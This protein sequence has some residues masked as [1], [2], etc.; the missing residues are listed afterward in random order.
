MTP[1]AAPTSVTFSPPQV[2]NAAQIRRLSGQHVAI[3][4]LSEGTH[5]FADL[6]D[7]MAARF[8]ADTGIRAQFIRRSTSNFDDAV[9]VYQ[10]LLEAQSPDIDVL[11]I[12]VIWPGALGKYLT[13][14]KPSLSAEATQH[15]PT[16]VENDTV[17]GRLIGLPAFADVGLLYYRMDLLEKY[18]FVAPPAT[19]DELEQQATRILAGERIANPDFSGYVY[20][21]AAGESLTCNVLEWLASSVAG[22]FV[23]NDR[24]SINSPEAVGILNRVR[25]WTGTLAPHNVTSYIEEDAR[26][27]FQLGNAA[28]MRNWPYAF[29]MSNAA[30]SPIKG[31]FGVAP[32]PAAPGQPHVGTAGG[33]SV[34]VSKYSRVPEAATEWVRYEASPETQAYRAV[35]LSQVPTIPAA[36]ARSDVQQAEPFLPALQDVVRVA[37]PSSIFGEKYPQAS[38]AIYRGVNQILNGQDAPPVL[39]EIQKQLEQ[40][41]Y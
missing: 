36:A 22:R 9:T 11:H 7:A 21:G 18:G 16:L 34:A 10:S 31:K 14:L 40:L 3:A 35:A 19:W 2:A 23:D 39:V 24:V 13:D 26:T 4:T 1:V 33:F 29:G 8:T 30:G 15:Y 20:Q 6:D 38:T 12:D 17:D 28:F 5:A 25:G 41:L 32:L 27:A 37:R